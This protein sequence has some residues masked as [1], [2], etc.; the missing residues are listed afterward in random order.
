MYSELVS[1]NT[2]SLVVRKDPVVTSDYPAAPYIENIG[3]R[4]DIPLEFMTRE[5]L[6]QN[7]RPPLEKLQIVRGRVSGPIRDIAVPA[8]PHS[9]SVHRRRS[10]SPIRST[11]SRISAAEPA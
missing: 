7:G 11:A 3:V 5:N 6:L 2:N 9:I 1:N 4:P 10:Q 8:R